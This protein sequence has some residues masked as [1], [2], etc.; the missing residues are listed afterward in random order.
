[1]SETMTVIGIVVD[2][3]ARRA[4]RVQEVITRYGED[5]ICRM[6]VPSPSK[7]NGLITL[8]FKGETGTAERFY[9]ELEGIGGIDAQMMRFPH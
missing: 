1:M 5:I 2:E 9:H 7:E 4:P 8:V 6:G 3:R